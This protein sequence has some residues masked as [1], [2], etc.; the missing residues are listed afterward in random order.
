[1]HWKISVTLYY[2]LLYFR[3]VKVSNTP[4]GDFI[5]SKKIKVKLTGDGTKFGK[6]LSVISFGFTVIDEGSLAYSAAGNHCLA[7]WKDTESYD[8]LKLALRDIIAEVETLISITACGITF[9]IEYYLGGD[10]KFLAQC[11][12]IDSATST[13]ACIWCHCPATERHLSRAQWSLTD[14]EHGART[15]EE[16][17]QIANCRSKK[18]N[19]SHV[20]IFPMIPLTR[21]VVDNLHMFL[22]VCDTLI[23]MLIGSLRTLDRVNQS[24]RVQSLTGL[25][26]LATFEN[27]VKELGVSGYSFWIGRESKKLKW[28]SLTG[29]EKLKVFSNIDL[30]SAFPDLPDNQLIQKLWKDFLTVHNLFSADPSV[31]TE[32]HIRSFE[33]Q[34]KAFVDSFVYLYPAKHVTPY[35]HCMMHH[36]AEFM[37]LHGSILPF[38]QQGLEKYNDIMTKDYF[39]STSH[40][41]QECLTQILQK[42][43]RIEHL[44]TH[45]AKRKKQH[46]VSCSNCNR[47]GHNRLTCSFLC[48]SC[49]ATPSCSHLVMNGQS[50][51]PACHQDQ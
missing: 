35:M 16:S 26:H 40:R 13:Y 43:N 38:T 49:G 1:M 23:D 17:I 47:E 18:Y 10:W 21:V 44:E 20:P 34:S 48:V 29:P 39:R 15:I 3:S 46:E 6:R 5:A 11:T 19:V 22:R 51:I 28:R 24:L 12:G 9:D 4:N 50:Q 42:R 7:I 25:T 41:G 33:E 14:E 8:T 2:N 32:D 45:G 37:I 27:T 30:V 31:I 36:V